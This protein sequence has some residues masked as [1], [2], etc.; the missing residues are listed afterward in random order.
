MFLSDIHLT[1]F[2][3]IAVYLS[4]TISAFISLTSGSE[5]AVEVGWWQ[6]GQVR[7]RSAGITTIVQTLV[8]MCPVLYK[9]QCCLYCLSTS[10]GKYCIR[11]IAETAVETVQFINVHGV[12]VNTGSFLKV[13]E[14]SIWWNCS[15]V[16]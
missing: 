13:S 3:A 14:S 15:S 2:I 12:S 4:C 1:Y 6:V 5:T 10:I 9:N 7:N 11:L 8:F 16:I